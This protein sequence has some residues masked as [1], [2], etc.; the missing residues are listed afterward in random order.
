M[1]EFKKIHDPEE[2]A[3]LLAS[4]L[5]ERLV[6]GKRVLWLVSGGS[7][8]RCAAEAQR[9]LAHTSHGLIVMQVDER[10]GP[11]GHPDSNWQKLLD[12]GFSLRGVKCYPVLAGAGLQ[13]TVDRYEERLAAELAAAD[14]VVALLGVG[15]DGHTAGILPDSPAVTATSLVKAYRGPDFERITL[16]PPALKRITWALVYAVSPDKQEVL[17]SLQHS[18]PVAKQPMQLLKSIP[19]VVVCNTEL[20]S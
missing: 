3:T 18:A 10:F 17:H 19:H 12:A 20:E 9:L 8:V 11:P 6:H 15:A 7:A 14:E 13:E 1:L 5:N 4:A 16:T 2:A